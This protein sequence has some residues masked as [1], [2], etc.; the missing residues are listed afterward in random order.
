MNKLL[1]KDSKLDINNEMA[2]IAIGT[3]NLTINV[4]GSVCINDYHNDTDLALQINLNP[5]AKLLYN[6]YND[7]VKNFSLDLRLG[8]DSYAEFNYS[9]ETTLES[10]LVLDAKIT[11]SFS[12]SKINF[13]GVTS[14]NG[15]IKATA[16]S[17]VIKDTKDN[18][19]LENLRILALNDAENMIVPNLLVKTD[20]VNAI[21]NTTIS[22]VSK[23][24]LFYL[25]SKGI[26]D[27]DAVQLIKN[28][29]LKSNLK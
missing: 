15:V 19:V 21:H 20:S 13:H 25:N 4:F 2:D 6:R 3:N 29:F 28:G 24:Y 5:G 16:T 23:D 18:E 17:E 27:N 12:T 8:S 1:V 26:N 22:S 11:G 10:S 7:N 14:E 9:L